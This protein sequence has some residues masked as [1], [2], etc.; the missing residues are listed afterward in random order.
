MPT[1][2]THVILTMILLDLI[3]DYLI[4]NHKRYLTLHTLFIGGVAGLLPDIDVPLGWILAFFGV[5]SKLWSHGWILH[6]PFFSLIFLIPGIFYWK[7]KKYKLATCFFCNSLWN[8]LSYFFR[9]VVRRGKLG[10]NNVVLAFFYPT[11]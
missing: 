4:K 8:N 3:R 10:R 9:L 6:S 1:A 5:H 2:V 7:E 11:F